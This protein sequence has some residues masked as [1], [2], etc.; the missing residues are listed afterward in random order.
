MYTQKTYNH[1]HT[2]THTN[3]YIYIY[4]Y[5][6]SCNLMGIRLGDSSSNPKP[7]CLHFTYG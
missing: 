6:H 2:H 1:T 4:I 3:I 5:T 7:T